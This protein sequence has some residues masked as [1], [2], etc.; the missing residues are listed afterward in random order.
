MNRIVLAS[1]ALCCL[2]AFAPAPFP[3]TGRTTGSAGLNVESLQGTWRVVSMRRTRSNGQHQDHKWDTNA[4]RIQKEQWGFGTNGN[5]SNT[6]TFAIDAS[7]TPA[8]IDWYTEGAKGGGVRGM[9]IIRRV[10]K[11]IEI[12]Y[13]FGGSQRATSFESIPDNF[14]LLTLE[15]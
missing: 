11:R 4:I 12:V 1:L 14:Y 10:G 13:Y 6:Y 3:R 2:T 8:T 9:G 7:R 5:V 15:R